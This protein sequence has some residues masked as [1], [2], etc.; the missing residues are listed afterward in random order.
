M[1]EGARLESVYTA[2]YRG[3]ESLPHRQ[4]AKPD[5]MVGLFAFW[6]ENG[7]VPVSACHQATRRA[8]TSEGACSPARLSLIKTRAVSRVSSS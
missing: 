6:R 5:L 4:I 1:A 8:S 3:F 2:T 7:Q